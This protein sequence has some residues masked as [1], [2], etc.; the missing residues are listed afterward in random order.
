[1]SRLPLL[2]ASFF[3]AAVWLPLP[4]SADTVTMRDGTM[5]EGTIISE[6]ADTVTMEVRVGGL[7]GTIVLQRIEIASVKTQPLAPDPVETEATKLRALAQAAKGKEAAD[8][9]VE[10]GDL[11]ARHTGYSAQAK[12]AYENAIL[13]DS[14][15]AKARHGLGH[16]KTADG[17]QKTDDLRRE[18]GLVPLG[19]VWIRP[20]ERSWLI[21]RRHQAQTDE[22]RIG[23]RQADDFSRAEVE[24][25]LALKQAEDD[26]R[27]RDAQR[28]ASGNALLSRYGYYMNGAQDYVGAVP[29]GYDG[30]GIDSPG[31]SAFFGTVGTG[32]YPSA[33]C[34]YG[35]GHHGGPHG[36]PHGYSPGFRWG[37]FSFGTSFGGWG[38]HGGYGWGLNIGGGSWNLNVG[39]FSGS[40]SYRSSTGIG[41][42]GF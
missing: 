33:G 10:V 40:S 35:G 26:A 6:D 30:V 13:A 24:R 28:L 34:V 2:S 41:F 36:R 23:P 37:N 27:R 3:V 15:H 11:Y 1:M 25:S 39:G 19:E 5:R 17:W 4:A 42:F 12:A 31:G 38:G 18:R 21:D 14:D 32:W 9:W 7:K 8:R 20:D 22:L 29:V 16:L